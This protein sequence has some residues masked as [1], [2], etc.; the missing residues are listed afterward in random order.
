MEAIRQELAQLRQS[1]EAGSTATALRNVRQLLA[2][3]S[4]LFDPHVAIAALE[5]LVDTARENGAEKAAR[6][7]I[8][9]RQTRPLA[10]SPL[11]QSLLLKLVGTKEEVQIA[12]EIQKTLKTQSFSRPMPY[13][14]PTAAPLFQ[15][16]PRTF[17]GACYNCGR[18]GHM[19]RECMENA[20]PRPRGRGLARR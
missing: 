11:L 1:Q 16:Q 18:R 17:N 19:A 10:D 13:P 2:R 12:K 20:R 9:L 7:S 6:Y 15:Y 8:I 5:H 4:T 3:P 14:Q